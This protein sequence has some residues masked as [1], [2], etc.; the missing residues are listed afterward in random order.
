MSNAPL[1]SGVV[2][3]STKPSNNIIDKDRLRKIQSSVLHDLKD[4]ILNSMGPAGSNSLILRGTSDADIVSEYSKDGNKIIKS[5]KYQYPIEMAIKAEIE[6]ATRYIEKTVGDG[7]S[8]VVVMSSLIFD[9]I[10]QA[11]EDGEIVT[12]PF[13]TMR[14][15]KE[16]VNIISEKIR[17]QGRECTLDDIYNIALISTNG[18]TDIADQLLEIY[19]EYGMN[20][21]IDVSAS[22]NENTYVKSYNGVTI[23]AGYSDPAMINNLDR[24]SCRIRSTED[25]KVHVYHFAEPIDTPEQLAYF[26]KIIE[27]NV[28]ERRFNK[29]IMEVP[30]VILVPQISRDAQA[31]MRRVV[32]MLLQFDEAHYSQKPQLLIVTNYTG[33]S[34]NYVDHISNL[35]GCKPIKKYIDDKIQK[36]DQEAGLAPTLSTVCDFCGYA[37]EVEADGNVTKFV[38]PDKMYEKDEN[39]SLILDEEG[40]PILSV[41]YNNIVNFIESQYKSAS[42]QGGNAGVLGS[43]KRQLNAVKSNMVEL[44]I[45]GIS[46][47]DRDSLRDLVE[48]AVLNTRSAAKNGVGYGANTMGYCIT[49]KICEENNVGEYN[50]DILTMMRIVNSAYNEMIKS[51]YRTVFN[52]EKTVEMIIEQIYMEGGK[53]YNINTSDYDGLVLTSIESEPTILDTIAK[54]VSLMSTANQVILMAPQ[55]AV[56]Y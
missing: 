29:R 7:T 21:F 43:L 41:T 16:C 15:L 17:A 53:P 10:K 36:A 12:D 55:L 8:S 18:N 54:I 4:A 35:C 25:Y 38:D 44:F 24:G 30:T 39:G 11:Y 46:I 50:E 13:E 5:I 3:N 6:N 33:L 22:T 49:R 19:K 9:S 56:H 37:G 34:E 28:I 2:L 23:E 14:L 47:S 20:V 31:Y 51:L 40:N 48:D 52:N 27:S 45:G 26:Q 1:T 42:A 32:Q